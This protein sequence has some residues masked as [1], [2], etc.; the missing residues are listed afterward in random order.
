VPELT[1]SPERFEEQM[2][3]LSRREAVVPLDCLLGDLRK[4][5]QP[6]RGRVVITFDDAAADVYEFAYPVLRRYGL[7]ATIFVP[8]GL[9]GRAEPFWWNRLFRLG[10]RG[11]SAGHGP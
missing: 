4:G 10:L 5:R 6:R 8:T 1:V 11:A 2:A 9:V 3:F 7:P